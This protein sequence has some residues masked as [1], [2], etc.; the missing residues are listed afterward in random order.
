MLDHGQVV[1]EGDLAQRVVLGLEQ[2]LFPEVADAA[3][4]LY[5]GAVVG[6]LVGVD[7]G[8]QFGSPPDIEDALAQVLAD[9]HQRAGAAWRPDRRRRAGAG[10][11][12]GGERVS[13]SRCDRFCFCRRG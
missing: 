2:L 1:F 5:R 3:G 10:W 11:N 7:A 9:G 13:R 8:Q 4:L 12:A 6:Q